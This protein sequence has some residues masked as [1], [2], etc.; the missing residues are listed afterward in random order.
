MATA[1]EIQKKILAYLSTQSD[2]VHAINI[3][4]ATGHNRITI[5][6]YLDV[7]KAAN[8]IQVRSVGQANLWSLAKEPSRFKV[9]IVDDEE[10]VVNLIKLT[11]DDTYDL[12]AAYDGQQALEQVSAHMPD[13]VILD[14]M[15]PKKDGFEVCKTI[16]GNILTRNIQ[17][18]LL[19]AKAQTV[20]K[21]KGLQSGADYHM[22]KP[23]DPQELEA[24]VRSTL[25]KKESDATKHPLTGLD[26]SS[27]VQKMI[28]F[29]KQS[30][31]KHIINITVE[32]FKDVVETSGFRSGMHTLQMVVKIIQSQM[33][34]HGKIDDFI[35]HTDDDKFIV[36]T[37]ADPK[38]LAQEIEREF[39][40]AL[41]FL[42]EGAKTKK[43]KLK[44]K[45]IAWDAMTG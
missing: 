24:L 43:L 39:T 8:K 44:A 17:V 1:D 27:A 34:R 42:L 29:A 4:Q 41:P 6:K 25:R 33:E 5:G 21:V 12:I 30:G 15:M 26:Q 9:L 11:L 40:S 14:V 20:D 35:G 22:T 10:P 23:F 18:I 32:G 31:N 2:G 36:I 16:K 13:L 28:A 19:T 37:S 45:S 3:A 38:K 7:L